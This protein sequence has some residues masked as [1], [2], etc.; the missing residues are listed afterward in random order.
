MV[1]IKCKHL[2]GNCNVPLLT[3]VPL[4]HGNHLLRCNRL[5]V[6]V[7]CCVAFCFWILFSLR[8]FD[9][10]RHDSVFS[11]HRENQQVFSPP[12][13]LFGVVSVLIVCPSDRRIRYRVGFQQTFISCYQ[14][15]LALWLSRVVFIWCRSR[16]CW[17]KFIDVCLCE[18]ERESSDLEKLVSRRPTSNHVRWIFGKFSVVSRQAAESGSRGES[19]DDRIFHA[20]HL[21]VDVPNAIVFDG[22]IF[23]QCCWTGSEVVV[24]ISEKKRTKR[25]PRSGCHFLKSIWLIYDVFSI[26]LG[27]HG[28]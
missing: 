6:T 7:C 23:F 28:A 15:S 9:I 25:I 19:K 21:R 13:C 3:H 26:L 5:S 14:I 16:S 18:C 4:L 27:A 12:L 24:F 1:C 10:M 2:N 8:Y 22:S 20:L 11:L 17:S